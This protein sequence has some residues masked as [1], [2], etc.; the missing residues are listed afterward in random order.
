MICLHCDKNFLMK[1]A[2]V[3]CRDGWICN[4]CFE[5]LGFDPSDRDGYKYTNYE[6]L[7]NGREYYMAHLWDDT[8][9]R[10]KEEIKQAALDSVYVRVKSAS[11]RPDVDATDEEI[12]VFEILQEMVFP[13]ELTLKRTSD[14]YVVASIGMQQIARIKYSDRAAWI[15]FPMLSKNKNDLHDPEDVRDLARK[16]DASIVIY[17]EYH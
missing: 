14:S 9:E 6:E 13:H 8:I 10:K 3:P 17:E 15:T 1:K 11:E 4:K 7:K 5:A 12:E 16:V 2:G